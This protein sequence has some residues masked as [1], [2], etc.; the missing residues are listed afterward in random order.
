[1]GVP[2]AQVADA[3]V[4][5]LHT[6]DGILSDP[7]WEI[8]TRAGAVF[9]LDKNHAG[10]PRLTIGVEAEQ[11][12]TCLQRRC[13]VTPGSDLVRDLLHHANFHRG[14]TVVPALANGSSGRA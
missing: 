3:R 5:R 1:M 13:F 11:K 4:L 14:K 8:V 10:N 2:V 7:G 9:A 6:T 12:S